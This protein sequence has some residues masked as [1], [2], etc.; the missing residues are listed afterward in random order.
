MNQ[1][2]TNRQIAFMIFG[3]VVGFGILGLP[4]GIAEEYGTA[5]WIGILVGT[6]IA[7]IFTYIVTYLG[8]HNEGKT[9][10]E[11]SEELVGKTITYIFLAFYIVY[12][13]LFF[14]FVIRMA[15][16]VIRLTILINTPTI[17]LCII[18]YIVMYYALIK[19]LRGIA[20]LCEFYGVIIISGY[21]FIYFIL[22]SQGR[23]INIRPFFGTGEISQYLKLPIATLVPYVG[24]EIVT[25]I[26][27]KK[28]KNRKVFKYTTL[29]V[30]FIGLLYMIVVE[31][32]I[33]VIG[34]DDIV[35]Y[36]DALIATIRR[37]DVHWLE[38]FERLDG[39]FLSLWIMS[40]FLTVTILGYGT[41]IFTNKIFKK[42]NYNVLALIILIISLIASQLPKTFDQVQ[43][44]IDLSGYI[45]LG[46]IIIIPSILLVVMKVKKNNQ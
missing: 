38:F 15:S 21:L 39:L 4:K 12:F 46:P 34:I 27:L 20:R 23:I 44:L 43:F 45:G 41:V 40:V 8:Y 6:I 32:C 2:I 13:F 18:F 22:A 29:M 11:Y 14:T 17:A 31:A 1:S 24:I 33:S 19:G 3:V 9:L 16:D 10:Y 25:F 30:A 7:I 37:V 35:H 28:D 26:P 36:K 42:I 5:A